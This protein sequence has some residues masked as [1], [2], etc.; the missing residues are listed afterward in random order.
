MVPPPLLSIYRQYKHDTDFVA[1][2]LATTARTYGY[3]AHLLTNLNA[4]SSTPHQ[5]STRLKGKA[6]KEAKK[7][8]N[9]SKIATAATEAKKYTVAIKDFIPLA[10]FI[11][12]H[13]PA[14]PVPDTFAAALNKVIEL[15]TRF[16]TQLQEEVKHGRSSRVDESHSYFVG[17]LKRVRDSLKPRMSTEASQ[18]AAAATTSTRLE[19]IFDALTIYEPK[20]EDV[21]DLPKA[22][23]A[24][25]KFA[26]EKDMV[27]EAEHQTSLVDAV[28]AFHLLFLDL[29]KIQNQV[30]WIWTNL[31]DGNFDVA[32]AALATNSAIDLARNLIDEIQPALNGHSM[33]SL[34]SAFHLAYCEKNGFDEKAATDGP[35]S[36]HVAY[37]LADYTYM[38]AY[39]L[40]E[41]CLGVYEPE[42]LPLYK[43][44]V[45]G[46]YDPTLDRSRMPEAKKFNEDLIIIMEMFTE[47]VTVSKI[48]NYPV[49]DEMMRGM[50]E[51]LKT[52]HC[53]FYLVF[54]TQIFLDTHHI[55]R[56]KV[57]TVFDHT[58]QQ[59]VYI[60]KQV[61]DHLE[62]HK[63]LTINAWPA[64]LNVGL[65]EMIRKV[66]WVVDDPIYMFKVKQYNFL[67]VP[68]PPTMKPNI[69]LR[70]SLVLS[71]LMLYHFRFELH[72]VGIA[73]ANV[74][75]SIVYTWHLYNALESEKLLSGKWKDMEIVYSLLRGSNMH[76][77]DRPTNTSE[78]LK[79][80][81]LQI[82]VSAAAFR[83][84]QNQ[85][86]DAVSLRS[87]AGPRC[88]SKVV[89]LYSMFADRYLRNRTTNFEWTPQHIDEILSHSTWKTEGSLAEGNLVIE[90]RSSSELVKAG[91]Q[92]KKKRHANGDRL[93]AEQLIESLV[94]ALQA[95]SIELV[96]PWLIM[97]Q[98][99]WRLLRDVDER[100]QP[101]LT[102]KYTPDYIERENQL[103]FVVGW[104]LAAASGIEGG[105]KDMRLMK[106]AS[107][108][109]DA[110]ISLTTDAMLDIVKSQ[111][112]FKVRFE[113]E[114]SEEGS[115]DEHAGG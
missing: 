33:Y 108:S 65:R 15:R 63:N 102:A 48:D 111:L 67:N 13:Q 56:D 83:T 7:N 42:R 57:S 8:N 54:A 1:S 21:E 62:F 53:P 58:M 86:R 80:F 18:A 25:S 47:L 69:M 68:P 97:H 115:D 20:A 55:L 112:G 11:A 22:D 106:L 88:I 66:R 46:H 107:V 70:S 34:G 60:G 103:P 96:F 98:H 5:P 43:P 40:L 31:K 12:S 16:S 50:K 35:G 75:G 6:R 93:P 45:F 30:R 100:C 104:I 71:G 64:S 99:C 4:S 9:V 24:L 28:I 94:L 90:Q 79:G 29:K 110:I 84:P 113:E 105:V 2:W 109:V 37:E 26:V 74:W 114:S 10:E 72:N 36:N 23:A 82:G 41:S 38:N 59:I 51:A 52:R 95:E 17:I 89:P 39:S 77:G 81:C 49:E 85:R 14:V 19:N 44:G 101:L 61:A 92:K 91:R 27:Y 73:V 3:P 87:R 76:V 32:A 78:C